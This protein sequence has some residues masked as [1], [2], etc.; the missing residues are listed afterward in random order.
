[1]GPSK[2]LLSN[3]IINKVFPK[4]PKYHGDYFKPK[5][6]NLFDEQCN[7]VGLSKFGTP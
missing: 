2:M 3:F 4:F 1:M 6:I 7:L 5:E